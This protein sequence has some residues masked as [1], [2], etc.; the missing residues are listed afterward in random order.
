[1]ASSAVSLH[2]RAAH[3]TFTDL[4]GKTISPPP[5]HALCVGQLTLS[6]FGEGREEPGDGEPVRTPEDAGPFEVRGGSVVHPAL[7]PGTVAHREFQV[8]IA[9]RALRE[10]TLVVLP[11]GIGKT[12]IAVLVAAEVLHRGRGRVLVLAPTRPLAQQHLE[13]LRRFLADPAGLELF[14][15]GMPATE[16]ARRWAAARAVVATPQCIANDLEAGRY[17]LSGCALVVFDEAHRAVG[18]YAY[19]PIGARYMRDRPGRLVLGLTASPGWERERAEEVCAALGISAVEARTE[20]DPDVAPYVQGTT[21]EWRTV[22]L[23]LRQIRARRWFEDALT[24]HVSRLKRLGFV[25]HRKKGEKASKKDIIRAGGEIHARLGKAGP[26]R[27]ALFGALHHQALALQSVHC[28]EL[29][30]TQGVAPALSYIG[31][32]EAEPKKKRSVKAFLADP[33]VARGIEHL[34]KHEG[35]S[36]AKVDALV[37]VVR[38][39][40]ARRPDSLVIAFSQFRDTIAGLLERLREEGITAERFVGQAHRGKDRGLKQSEQAEL[41]ERFRRRE[42]NV[43]VASSVAEEGLDVPSVDLVVFYEPV[44]SEIRTI[45][46]RGRTGRDAVGRIVVLVTEATR[47]EAFARAEASRERKMR[48]VVRGMARK[49]RGEG[50]QLAPRKS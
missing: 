19:V 6:A 34:R 44:P 45:Q 39:Q 4:P 49:G 5:P 30:E 21:I 15:G 11:T 24:K 26:R 23:A 46:R 18:D 2:G 29:L 50:K 32:L 16:R 8:A 17:D 41:L 48:G 28:L 31:R 42:F 36:H 9:L 37:E 38:E 22:Q 3:P 12:L 20:E 10:G 40:L 14:T 1:M 47:D 33:D 13:S 35:V 43:L 25:R 27:G 7:A